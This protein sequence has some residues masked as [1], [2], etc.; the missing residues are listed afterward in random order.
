M[1]DVLIPSVKRQMTQSVLIQSRGR[2]GFSLQQNVRLGTAQQVWYTP[3]T[4]PNPTPP[5][6]RKSSLTR[7]LSYPFV[8]AV[9]LCS[10]RFSSVL[11]FDVSEIEI[12]LTLSFIE[13]KIH[14]QY[15]ISN[16][17]NQPVIMSSL[18]IYHLWQSDS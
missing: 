7:R 1:Q 13:L 10:L 6:Y 2:R 15:L 5:P 17:I 4:S 8:F 3:S 16:L 12:R 14:H 9:M 11:M 18:P